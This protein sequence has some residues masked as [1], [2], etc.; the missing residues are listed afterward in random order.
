MAVFS[1]TVFSSTVY[2]T[3]TPTPALETRGGFAPEQIK[4]YRDYLEKLTGINKKQEITEAV[5]EAA[6]AITEIPVDAAQVAAI[7]FDR[8]IDFAGLDAELLRITKYINNLERIYQEQ[9]RL[10]ELDDEL[11]L[12]LLL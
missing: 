2:L 4:R 8:P 10:R 1:N 7:A 6:E 3:G 11:A 12:M 9:R 5:I